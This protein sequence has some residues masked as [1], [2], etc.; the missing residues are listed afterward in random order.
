MANSGIKKLTVGN[1]LEPDP[2]MSA[3]VKVSFID[4]SKSN[5]DADEW[6][7]RFLKPHLKHIQRTH[8]CVTLYCVTH[9]CVLQSTHEK[10]VRVRA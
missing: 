3:F 1:W 8:K 4:G 5:I 6:A 10:S 9:L 2:V 7:S